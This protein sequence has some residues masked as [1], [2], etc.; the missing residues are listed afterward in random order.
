MGFVYRDYRFASDRCEILVDIQPHDR[1]RAAR[2]KCGRKGPQYDT[3]SQHRFE[4][5]PLWAIAV[6]YS[7]QH[8][9]RCL[10]VLGPDLG[11]DGGNDP[12]VGLD[13]GSD[14]ESIAPHVEGRLLGQAGC[15][16]AGDLREGWR[17]PIGESPQADIQ[18]DDPRRSGLS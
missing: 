13:L 15:E 18:R 5:V 4:F 12:P 3:L 14:C 17:H 11:G 8:A 6:F 2:S 7:L 16:S 10:I 9:T 1:S